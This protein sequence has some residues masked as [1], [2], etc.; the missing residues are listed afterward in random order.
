[1][2]FDGCER[3]QR[4]TAKALRDTVARL[5]TPE[6]RVVGWSLPREGAEAAR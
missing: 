1:M 3:H 5:L 4:V 2:A 6:R